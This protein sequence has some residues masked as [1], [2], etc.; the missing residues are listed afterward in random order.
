MDK[1]LDVWSGR[2]GCVYMP[3]AVFPATTMVI[4]KTAL[5]TSEVDVV[6]THNLFSVNDILFSRYINFP[7]E[8]TNNYGCSLI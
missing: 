4:K 7:L 3:E 8:R 2:V 1:D 6:K 5:F